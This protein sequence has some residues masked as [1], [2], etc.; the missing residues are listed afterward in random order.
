MDAEEILAQ[1]RAQQQSA[2]DWTVFPL[3]RRKVISGIVGW[4]FGILFGLLLL[5]LVVPNVIPVNYQH[6]VPAAI[7]TT[8]L[9]I[10]L[11]FIVVGSVWMLITDSIRLRNAERYLI[12]LTEQDYIKQEGAKITQVPLNAVQHVTARGRAPIDRTVPTR[13]ENMPNAGE[14]LKGFF[15]GRNNTAKGQRDRRRR[16]RTPSSLAFLDTRSNKEVTVVSD[17]AY[18]DPYA[19]G[20]ELKRRIAMVQTTNIL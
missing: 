19:I 7:V 12:V 9:L 15:I 20:G 11:L 3:L 14:N 5:L 17:D 10:V 1:I 2:H 4:V 18:G 16:S 8:F 6:G 13:D